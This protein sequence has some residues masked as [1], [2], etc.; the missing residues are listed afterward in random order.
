MHNENNELVDNLTKR[1]SDLEKELKEL[2]SMLCGGNE[3]CGGCTAQGC[4]TCSVGGN[5]STSANCTGAKA[6]AAEALNIAKEAKEKL[7]NK[8]GKI[9]FSLYSVVFFTL[10]ILLLDALI[11]Y[12]MKYLYYHRFTFSWSVYIESYDC[13]TLNL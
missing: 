7:L 11:R 1:I 10:Y 12:T 6:L 8:K 2:N 4:E 13:F 9:Q 3:G 5:N